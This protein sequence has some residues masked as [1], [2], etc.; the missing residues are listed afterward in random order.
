MITEIAISVIT[1]GLS[2]YSIVTIQ[3]LAVSKR[4]ANGVAALSPSW[5]FIIAE[6]I[7]TRVIAARMTQKTILM[8]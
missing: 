4:R 3:I 6:P 7:R 1:V 5:T 8:A 2:L